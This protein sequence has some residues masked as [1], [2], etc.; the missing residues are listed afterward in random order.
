MKERGN[1]FHLN[2]EIIF[3]IFRHVQPLKA[4]EAY[5]YYFL[6]K[7]SLKL[8]ATGSF[9]LEE[10]FQ[11]FAQTLEILEKMDYLAR[12]GED[13][14]RYRLGRRKNLSSRFNRTLWRFLK[15]IKEELNGDL[16]SIEYLQLAALVLVKRRFPFLK[17]HELQIALERVFGVQATYRQVERLSSLAEKIVKIIDGFVRH[18][19]IRLKTA[20][21]ALA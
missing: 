19:R 12:E 14:K 6:L 2:K 4:A 8:P 7:G 3:D 1:V 16:S 17:P 11:N 9:Q 10:D 13:E 5:F 15:D 21:Q 20:K 18:R